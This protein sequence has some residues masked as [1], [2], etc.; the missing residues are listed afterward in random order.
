MT[1]VTKKLYSILCFLSTRIERDIMSNQKVKNLIEKIKHFFTYV[2]GNCQK[3]AKDFSLCTWYL[4]TVTDTLS[5]I[6]KNRE[7]Y[8]FQLDKSQIILLENSQIPFTLCPLVFY[9][10]RTKSGKIECFDLPELI[11]PE[12]FFA[13]LKHPDVTQI[14]VTKGTGKEKTKIA[15]FDR[16]KNISVFPSTQTQNT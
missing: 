3:Q 15:K 12:L 9:T 13:H 8:C 5:L 11:Y 14:L 1:V 2:N 10:F 6:S 7:I 4:C 16:E